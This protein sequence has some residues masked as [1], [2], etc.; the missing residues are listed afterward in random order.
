VPSA[1]AAMDCTPIRTSP[2]CSSAQP[3]SRHLADQPSTNPTHREGCGDTSPPKKHSVLEARTP[4]PGDITQPL[5]RAA[6]V[7]L[8]RRPTQYDTPH[9]RGFED[10][11]VVRP[12]SLATL[13]VAA[14]RKHGALGAQT[15][16]LSACLRLFSPSSQLRIVLAQSSCALPSPVC[17]IASPPRPRRTCFNTRTTRWT[18]TRGVTRRSQSP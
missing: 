17:R 3:S 9:L 12:S 18:G 1:I 2:K 4:P 8:L 7:P 6:M 16:N 14:T 5:P 15:T 13:R 10:T 11:S